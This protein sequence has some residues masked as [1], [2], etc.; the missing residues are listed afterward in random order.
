MLQESVTLI[1]AITG[2]VAAAGGAWAARAAYRSA[3]GAQ[4]AV[5][6]AQRIDRRGLLRDLYNTAHRVVAEPLA[7]GSL[8]EELKAEYRVLAASSGQAGG[9]REKL[10]IQRAEA[11]EKE[12]SSLQDEARKLIETRARLNGNASE[13]EL[14]LALNKLD[15][16]LVQVLSIKNGLERELAAT[17]GDNRIHG[18]HRIKAFHKQ[19]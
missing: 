5:K 10:L 12:V 2:L 18:E 9:S 1:V 13:E 4:E 7:I 16:G 14:T 15:G 11:K 19:R 6:Q 17:A 3:L 8:V